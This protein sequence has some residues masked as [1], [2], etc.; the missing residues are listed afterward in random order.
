[1]AL[2][3]TQRPEAGM[4]GVPS[5]SLIPGVRFP[6]SQ[7]ISEIAEKRRN[8]GNG[9][10]SRSASFSSEQQLNEP[11]DHLVSETR[12]IRTVPFKEPFSPRACGDLL[13]LEE[14]MLDR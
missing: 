3:V 11:R 10:S 5:T 4:N 2:Q 14:A 13:F 6:K 9:A 7:P 12:G 8:F 1:M